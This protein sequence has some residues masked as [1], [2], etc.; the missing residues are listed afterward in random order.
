MRTVSKIL[1]VDDQKWGRD[2]LAGLLHSPDYEFELAANGVEALALAARWLPDLILLDVMMPEMD[3]FEVC[4][5]LRASPANANVP[6]IMV[7]ALDDNA[8]RLEGIQAG[9][10]DFITKPYNRT[11]LSARVRTVT[12]LNR[13]RQIVSERTKFERLFDLSPD[14]I[15]VVTAEH[16]VELANPAMLRILA[17]SEREAIIGKPVTLFFA[18]EQRAACSRW[19]AAT[20]EQTLDSPRVESTFVR[21]QGE[22]F[23]VEIT[24]AHFA[25]EGS[26]MVQLIVRDISARR[27]AELQIQ[28]QLER[29]RVLNTVGATIN[30][31]LE[32]N[33]TLNVL[34]SQVLTQLHMD[35][36]GLLLFDPVT[37]HLD[38][39]LGQGFGTE[40]YRRT[41]L[42]L[43]KMFAGKA[44]LDRR[45][46][47]VPDL[48]DTLQRQG[49]DPVPL[50]ADEHFTAYCA[51]PLIAKGKLKGV[52]EIFHRTH[53]PSDPAWVDFVDS[54][55]QQ[56]ALAIDNAELFVNLQRANLD[57]TRAYDATLAGWSHAL[58][59]RD[60]ETGDH[61]QRVTNLTVALARLLGI[62]ETEIVHVRRGAL[63]H[64]IGK[65]GIPDHILLKPGTLTDTERAIMERHPVLAYELLSPI[66]FLRPALAIPYGHHE[67]WDGTGYPR[68]LAGEAIPF[69]ARIFA[70][71]D[72]WDA[73]RSDRPYRPAWERER[74]LE[75]IRTLAG[76]HL[77][78][79]VVEAF[80]KISLPA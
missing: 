45:V 44:A 37:N 58:D 26:P 40:V 13:Y 1:I 59:L 62:P 20:L 7:T 8:S 49:S 22:S 47:L 55:A 12:R 17:L 57:L 63:L 51:A 42:P 43:G 11:E 80:F 64:D 41:H 39:A 31:S 60:N 9:A 56:A 25:T 50:F 36:V 67:K 68:K 65:L 38:Y 29:L 33:I 72:V 77:D 48:R 53:L 3:G 34:L 79:R 54:L 21:A 6:I 15:L 2:T 71:V 4:R 61:S 19:I 28:T 14:G 10:D 75:H 46:M 30:G 78:P 18:A 27:Q 70:V 35:A 76:S 24:F 66:E 23:P 16:T 52:L 69:A 5:R 32:L 73:L 74:V